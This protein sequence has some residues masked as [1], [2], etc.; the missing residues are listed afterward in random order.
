MA[1]ETQPS[2]MYIGTMRIARMKEICQDTFGESFLSVHV[3]LPDRIFVVR[4]ADD[5]DMKKMEQFTAKHKLSLIEVFP[6][7]AFSVYRGKKQL[8]PANKK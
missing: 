8:V 4:V 7:M 1:S 6:R 2:R 5:A 3:K